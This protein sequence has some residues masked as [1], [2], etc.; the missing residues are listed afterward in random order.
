[1][2]QKL[3]ISKKMFC[4][5][6]HVWF[7]LHIAICLIFVSFDIVFDVQVKIFFFLNVMLRYISKRKFLTKGTISPIFIT[8]LLKG[9][10]LFKLGWLLMM[11]TYNQGGFLSPWRMCSDTF[12]EMEKGPGPDNAEL[13]GNIIALDLAIY[14]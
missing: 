13:I 1:M 14:G 10:G 3:R 4:N 9:E 11:V 8:I 12:Q 7:S 5:I 6:R 2:F